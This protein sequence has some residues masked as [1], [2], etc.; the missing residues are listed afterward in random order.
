MHS[1]TTTQRQ[2]ARRRDEGNRHTD[3]PKAARKRQPRRREER[4]PE[5]RGGLQGHQQY[6]ALL[7]SSDHAVQRQRL[8]LRQR[9]EE[10]R[11]DLPVLSGH[12]DQARRNHWG[13]N[14]F[15]LITC[16]KEVAIFFFF[17]IFRS[18]IYINLSICLSF[19]FFLSVFPTFFRPS[20]FYFLRFFHSF[21]LPFF[22][23]SFFFFLRFFHSLSFSFSPTFSRSSFFHFLFFLHF[24][25]LS[26][27]PSFLPC[28]VRISFISALSYFLPFSFDFLRSAAQASKALMGD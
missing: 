18:F 4:R 25:S 20:F 1:Y 28:F 26:F 27:F 10:S 11:R 6:Q 19:Y 22:R 17:F 16:A 7:T 9:P 3:S 14:R 8:A 5:A 24:L 12:H 15:R 2:M 21:S 23:S 13:I